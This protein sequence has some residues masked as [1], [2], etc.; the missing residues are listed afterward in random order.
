WLRHLGTMT[1][2]TSGGPSREVNPEMIALARE[3]R[4]R[5]QKD[6][7]EAVGI[8]AGQLSKIENGLMPASAAV[9]EKIAETLDYPVTFFSQT[10]RIFGPS[11]GEFYHRKRKAASA[12]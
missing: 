3:A 2:A 5:T 4:G 12:R 10:N 11:T 6:L 1:G 8:S 7:A 9:V